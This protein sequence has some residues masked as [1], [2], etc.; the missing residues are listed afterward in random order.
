[1]CVCKSAAPG[2]TTPVCRSLPLSLS[3]SLTHTHTHTHTQHLPQ[4]HSQV[5]CTQKTHAAAGQLYRLCCDG[6]FSSRPAEFVVDRLSF[7]SAGEKALIL[8]VFA[9]LILSPAVLGVTA[10]GARTPPPPPPTHT[11]LASCVCVFVGGGGGGVETA[12]EVRIFGCVCMS[13]CCCSRASPVT[14]G[15]L[16]TSATQIGYTLHCQVQLMP[17]LSLSP[18]CRCCYTWP[19][20]G[21]PSACLSAPHGTATSTQTA[22]RER[23]LEL[24]NF[25]FQGLYL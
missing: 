14:P 15:L 7:K 17:A 6:S 22:E 23:E 1:M 8:S 16:V 18:L 24:E 11:Q 19:S 9:S 2:D 25:I 12:W 10:R 21:S 13:A 4:T 5:S 20:P 3:L